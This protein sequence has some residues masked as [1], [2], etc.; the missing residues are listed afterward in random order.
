MN[1]TIKHR[2]YDDSGQVYKHLSFLFNKI[3]FMSKS[4]T[5]DLGLAIE[6]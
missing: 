6:D 4:E 1:N 3:L 5:Y 2:G